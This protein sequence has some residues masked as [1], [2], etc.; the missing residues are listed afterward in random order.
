[1]HVADSRVE[2]DP[3]DDVV[4]QGVPEAGSR[5]FFGFAAPVDGA[6]TW[7]STN[8]MRVTAPET[9]HGC[10][11]GAKLWRAEPHERIRHETRPAG[12]GRMKAPGG[13]ENLEVQAVGRG[14]PDH[15]MPLPRAGR[16][17][18][19]RKPH[20]RSRCMFRLL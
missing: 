14:K 8:V 6:S 1:L 12:S 2:Q 10:T 3:E 7:P 16:R 15:F 5:R 4:D 19:G 13:C 9:A 18:R 17:C 20:G 11:R